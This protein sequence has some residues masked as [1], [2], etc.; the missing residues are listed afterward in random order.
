MQEKNKI[1]EDTRGLKEVILL[2]VGYA[3][4]ET[5]NK[6]SNSRLSLSLWYVPGTALGNSSGYHPR[7]ILSHSATLRA[8]DGLFGCHVWEAVLASNE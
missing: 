3:A 5:S 6:M 8:F 1:H 2:H 7:V 4:P